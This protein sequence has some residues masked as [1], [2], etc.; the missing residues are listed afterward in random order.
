MLEGFAH[1]IF[2]T[3]PNKSEDVRRFINNKMNELQ[4]KRL[5]KGPM[6]TYYEA[7]YKLYQY[8]NDLMMR[9]EPYE[10]MEDKVERDRERIYRREKEDQDYKD[11]L[12][13]SERQKYLM[14]RK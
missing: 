10:L 2:A 13:Q 12:Y 1:A 9:Y 6:Q 3:D 7:M 14:E 5:E 8:Y 4:M 11:L